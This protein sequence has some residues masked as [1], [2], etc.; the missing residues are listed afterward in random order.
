MEAFL[1]SSEMVITTV[2]DDSYTIRWPVNGP[3]PFSHLTWGSSKQL[4][5]GFL[6]FPHPKKGGGSQQGS[7]PL[8]YQS[9]LGNVV[10][11]FFRSLRYGTLKLK[12]LECEILSYVEWMDRR[13]SE[14]LGA[15]IFFFWN[16]SRTLW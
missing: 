5:E 9:G 14:R 1:G 16:P 8:T 3:Y 15:A 6:F 11:F 7:N 4:F 13:E 10:F 12:G 2:N